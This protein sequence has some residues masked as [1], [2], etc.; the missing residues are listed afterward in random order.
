[1]T[2]LYIVKKLLVL[3]LAPFLASMAAES[4]IQIAHWHLYGMQMFR[5]SYGF[6]P[7]RDQYL[8]KHL[9]SAVKGMPRKANLKTHTHK[10]N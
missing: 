1:M 6:G 2:Q 9:L 7:K 4:L 5:H 3:T 10:K 8:L